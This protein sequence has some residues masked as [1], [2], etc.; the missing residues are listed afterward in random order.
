MVLPDLRSFFIGTI[1]IIPIA[2]NII[3]GVQINFLVGHFTNTGNI[4]LAASTAPSFSMASNGGFIQLNVPV[5][6]YNFLVWDKGPGFPYY[7]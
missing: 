3:C 5:G 6:D 4:L 2:A 7:W 1:G